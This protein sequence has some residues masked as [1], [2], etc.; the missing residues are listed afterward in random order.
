M[1][2]NKRSYRSPRSAKSRNPLASLGI[3]G[4]IFAWLLAAIFMPNDS[5]PFSP[6]GS[7]ST[8]TSQPPVLPAPQAIFPGGI[9]PATYPTF[10]QGIA[11]TSNPVPPASSP[12]AATQVIFGQNIS[13]VFEARCV[14]V[15][16]GDTI[17][18]LTADNVQLKIR[19]SSIDAPESKQAYG[20]VAKQVLSDM[21]FG[22]TIQVFQ[23]GTDRYQRVIAFI[24]VNG[25]NINAEM[26]RNGLAWHYRQYS[27]S[28]EL[29]QLE[30]AARAYR[31]GLWVDANPVYPEE[32]RKLR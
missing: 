3:I 7:G 18:A 11:P 19:L 29:Q 6:G 28:A 16:D 10:P 30:D 8:T 24:G 14:G 20:S 25:V 31:S 32:F 21:C 2:R 22:K 17:T 27:K 5:Q 23:T 13:N 26:I 15:S 12:I 9:P 4:G 1:A